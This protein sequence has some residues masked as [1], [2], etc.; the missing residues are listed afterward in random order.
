MAP[1]RLSPHINWT[2]NA[3]F[4][5]LLGK[6]YYPQHPKKNETFTKKE[7]F[8]MFLTIKTEIPKEKLINLHN[9]H[10]FPEIEE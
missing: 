1:Q 5:C 6:Q 3:K 4:A 10:R 2:N 9:V 7:R 8:W